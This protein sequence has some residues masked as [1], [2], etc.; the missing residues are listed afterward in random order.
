MWC[1]NDVY[2]VSPLCYAYLKPDAVIIVKYDNVLG[3][4]TDVKVT[5]NMTVDAETKG[6]MTPCDL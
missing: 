5:E 6:T 1:G 3:R 2:N 4:Q